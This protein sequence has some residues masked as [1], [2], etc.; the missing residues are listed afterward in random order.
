M[1]M[2]T[3]RPLLSTILALASCTVLFAQPAVEQFKDIFRVENNRAI[4][5]INVDGILDEDIWKSSNIATDFYQKTPYYAEGADP[6]TEV[7]FTYDD[8]YL[9]MA[10]M[11]VQK[12]PVIIQSLKRDEFWNNDGIA[13][14]LDPLNT[15]TNAF[16]FGVTAAG[17]QWDAQF[18]QNS[19][20]NADW[21][22]SWKAEAKVYDG[23]WTAEIAVPFKILRYNEVNITWGLN[24]V[25]GI[26]GI[27][28]F[29]NWTAVPESFW[30]PN[31]AFAGAMVWDTPPTK[32]SGNY[33]II[34]YV[35]STILK[36]KDKKT[37]LRANA[38]VDARFALTSTL[39]ADVTI[40]PDFSQIEVDEQV[41]NLTRFSIFLPEKRTFFLENS[42]V[43]GNFGLGPVTPFFSRRIGLDENGQAVP[44]LYGLRATGNISDDVRIGIMN[45]HT[46]ANE[47]NTGQNQAAFSVQKRFGLSNVQALFA[48][49]QAF[50]K[51]D[52]IKKDF[53]RNASLEGLFKTDDG[54]KTVWVGVHQ[55]YKD[56]FNNKN[57]FY[58]LGG[59]YQ[60]P[61]WNIRSSG[62]IVQDN[63]FTDLGFNLRI[64]NYDAIRDT[65]IRL[66]FNQ[67]ESSIDYTIRPQEG[68]IQRHNFGIE[69][70]LTYNPDWSFNERNNRLSYFLRFQNTS[71]IAVRLTNDEVELQ[72]PFSF[73]SDGEPLPAD[74]YN[75]S[76][77]N[78]EY[79]SDGRKL[80]Q[81]EL[82]TRVGELY[83]GT[84]QQFM[85][86]ANYRVQ[87]WGNFGIQYQ[88]NNLVFPTPYGNG[89]ITALL[90]KVEIGFTRDLIW[91]TLFQ[92]V[93]QADF[94]GINSRLQWRFAPMSD[95]F[96]VYIDNYDFLPNMIETN[97][98]AIALKIN[99]WY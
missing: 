3:F 95:L 83:N 72:F 8:E 11:C 37:A 48:N 22:N 36:E 38:G 32:K 53:S 74:R 93:D 27:N 58:N 55:S 44:L 89:K 10:A 7:R 94:M 1:P 9:Y 24:I 99:Y 62:M 90:S 45:T 82:S 69:N 80:F 46:T 18:A 43:F 34:P 57:G 17:A 29:H 65:S 56:G 6:R 54:Q 20:I 50:D 88:Y 71:E 86:G 12:N 60:N 64:D 81:Y 61:Q 98:R 2:L 41:T 66:G 92:F 96:L 40:N 63:Y 31:P 97:N 33:N 91:T 4:D 49:R 87:P 14:I 67:W 23:Y 52:P 15:R 70:T 39:N 77:I 78:F 47:D 26:Q 21:S 68:K 76:S 79:N 5:P 73:V 59:E 13:M 51:F 16:L 28:E 35:T 84:I 42:D 75:Y 85:L 19:G 25:R 30:P